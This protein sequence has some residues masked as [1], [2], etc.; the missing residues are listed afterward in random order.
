MKTVAKVLVAI[1][2]V[3][4]VPLGISYVAHQL[5]RG[6]SPKLLCWGNLKQLDSAKAEWAWEHHKTTNDTPVDEDLFGTNAYIRSKPACPEGGTYRFGRVGAKAS[7]T[8]PG[9]ILPW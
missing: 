3:W 6:T 1:F 4:F 8:V 7:C 5:P 9:H 2:V